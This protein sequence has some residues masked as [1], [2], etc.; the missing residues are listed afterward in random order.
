MATGGQRR[1]SLP[2]LLLFCLIP[3]IGA[4]VAGATAVGGSSAIV[5]GL[6]FGVVLGLLAAAF[7][8]FVAR[9]T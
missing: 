6:V 4:G 2:K 7:G 5:F 8:L 3:A 1:G 9:H